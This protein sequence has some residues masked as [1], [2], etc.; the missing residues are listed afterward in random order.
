MA[1]VLWDILWLL[2]PPAASKRWCY[3]TDNIHRHSSIGCLYRKRYKTCLHL[4]R[5]PWG[6][7]YD[8]VQ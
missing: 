6:Q 8:Y 3:R 2:S 4:L 5:W 1:L 7:G